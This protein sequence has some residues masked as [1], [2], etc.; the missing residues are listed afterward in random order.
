MKNILLLLL[1]F[2]I[3]CTNNNREE[4]KFRIL[5]MNDTHSKN[6]EFIKVS[7]DKTY[8]NIYG[9]ASRRKTFIDEYRSTND[10]VILMHAGDTIAG[11][12]F[13]IVYLGLDEVQIMNDIGFDV[14]TLGNHEF[15][16][17][18]SQLDK[19]I[20][21][22]HFPTIACNVYFIGTTNR[23]VKPYIIT[24]INGANIAIVGVLQSEKRNIMDGLDILEIEDEVDSL[25]KLL[26]EVPL[27]ST[28]DV[29]ILLSHSGIDVDKKIA[30]DIPNTFNIIVGGHSHTLLK[31]PIF[32]KNTMIV[33]AG[34][35]G[36]YIGA[37]DV[38]FK[39]NK[40]SSS[41]YKLVRLDENIKE[42][43]TM[44]ATI[45]NMQ[46][47]VDK[48]FNIAIAN[49]SE[50]LLDDNIRSESV[51]LGNFVADV[52]EASQDSIDIALVNSGSLRGSLYSGNVTLGNI[53]EFFPF[54][55]L[56]VLTTID[57]KLLKRILELS[58]SSRGEGAFM[59]IS[60][61]A[62]VYFDSNGNILDCYI[63]GEK[64]EDNKKYTVAVADYI[65]GGGE[66]YIDEN[67]KPLFQYGDNVIH[68]GV[69]MR[70]LIIKSLKEGSI[71]IDNKE[72]II[73]N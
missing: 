45:S 39:N 56:I 13:S 41:D 29:L 62:T 14:A 28:N 22:R 63:K 1:F 48:R 25:K 16:F 21:S 64:V 27:K 65:F 17:G 12:V 47:E 19:V 23:Y 73:F 51:A 32:I 71:E 8:T 38:K 60:K 61:N 58:A 5:H 55:N 72:R 2:I 36:E 7:K 6:K 26:K 11:S 46:I 42:D 9:G 20:E 18:V 59:Q 33:Q 50:N 31:E 66:N 67:G 52:V 37:I 44:L 69:D 30:T 4:I 49:L 70:D 53:Y 40:Y 68:T 34:E 35:Y 24:N 54:D 10:N 3:S 15:D 57:G 43:K